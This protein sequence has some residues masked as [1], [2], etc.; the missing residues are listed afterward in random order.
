MLY[1][2]LL[3]VETTYYDRIFVSTMPVTPLVFNDAHLTGFLFLIFPYFI[4]FPIF[5]ESHCFFINFIIFG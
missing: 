3:F 5:R 2:I 4:I 1:N